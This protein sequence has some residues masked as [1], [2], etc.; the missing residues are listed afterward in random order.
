M[1]KMIAVGLLVFSMAAL[2]QKPP[3]PTDAKS[4]EAA[5]ARSVTLMQQVADVVVKD[6]DNCQMM[7]ADITALDKNNPGVMA[8]GKYAT[9]HMTAEQKKAFHAKYD[10]AFRAANKRLSDALMAK[11]SQDKG[12]EAALVNF[13]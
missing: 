2:A 8:Q 11:C 3:M 13:K 9:D 6:K 5:A 7:A 4:M 10:A 12:V 1:R